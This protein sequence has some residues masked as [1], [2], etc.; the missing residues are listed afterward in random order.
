MIMIPKSKKK[1]LRGKICMNKFRE[2]K[3]INL[4]FIPS[5]V[6]PSFFAMLV[7]PLVHNVQI[8]VMVQVHSCSSH[9]TRTSG[10][11]LQTGTDLLRFI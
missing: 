2:G 11:D 10:V 6:D 8:R 9:P 5:L 7:L 1:F 4:V 3:S